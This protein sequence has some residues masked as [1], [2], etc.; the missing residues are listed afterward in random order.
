MLVSVPG[1]SAISSH[2][3]CRTKSLPSPGRWGLLH[4]Y[5]DSPG[6]GQPSVAMASLKMADG[7]MTA[8]VRVGSGW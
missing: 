1:A 3:G 6:H 5:E 7:R 2:S 4:R 8:S